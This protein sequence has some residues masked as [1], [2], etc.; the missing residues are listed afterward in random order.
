V[1]G[2]NAHIATLGAKEF[3]NRSI[4]ARYAMK[5]L[6]L[7]LASNAQF[8]AAPFFAVIFNVIFISDNSNNR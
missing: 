4:D 6:P 5:A 3:L 2:N 7:T 8:A 1:V